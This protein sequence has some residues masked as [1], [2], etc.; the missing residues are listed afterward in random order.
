MQIT[1]DIPTNSYDVRGLIFQ[2]LPKDSYLDDIS[3][4]IPDSTHIF[5]SIRSC[6]TVVELKGKKVMDRLLKQQM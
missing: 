6:F 5:G 4:P 1:P 3:Q 2:D